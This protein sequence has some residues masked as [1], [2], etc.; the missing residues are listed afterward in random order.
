TPAETHGNY[1]GRP[2]IPM[3]VTT[4]S[5]LPL[6]P[7]GRVYRA[8]GLF[9]GR[10]YLLGDVYPDARGSALL[11]SEGPL[12]ATPPT[13]V[14]LTVEPAGPSTEPTGVPVIAWPAP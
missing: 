1:R 10:W 3:A 8:W 2:G 9:A 14:K 7:A 12:L 4:F 5:S 11:V 6:A 13:A